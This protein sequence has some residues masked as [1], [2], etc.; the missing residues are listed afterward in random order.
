MQ[1]A[2]YDPTKVDHGLVVGICSSMSHVFSK[3]D[4]IPVQEEGDERGSFAVSYPRPF[5]NALNSNFLNNVHCGSEMWTGFNSG[6]MVRRNVIG[7]VS[8]VCRCLDVFLVE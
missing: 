8:Y 7:T 4:G 3:Y 5:Q 2:A 1:G 6:F